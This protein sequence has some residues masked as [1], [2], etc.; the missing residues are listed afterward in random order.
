VVAAAI[1]GVA[2]GRRQLFIDGQQLADAKS[3]RAVETVNP[4]ALPFGGY[5]QP[6]WGREMGHE[7]LGSHTEIKDVCTQL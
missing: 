5:K 2:G 3:G 4:A 1:I 7:A 6:G